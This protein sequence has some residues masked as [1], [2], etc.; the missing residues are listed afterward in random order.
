MKQSYFVKKNIILFVFI[1][2][3]FFAVSANSR[4]TVPH[5]EP[6]R[7]TVRIRVPHIQP[8]E[9]YIIGKY[10]NATE[11]SRIR[12]QVHTIGIV[13]E[14]KENARRNRQVTQNTRVINWYLFTPDSTQ[15]GYYEITFNRSEL[16]RRATFG[17]WRYERINSGRRY[18]LPTRLPTHLHHPSSQRINDSTRIF[19]AEYGKSYLFHYKYYKCQNFPSDIRWRFRKSSNQRRGQVQADA[20][21][22]NLDSMDSFWVNDSTWY[23]VVVPNHYEPWRELH[24]TFQR[25]FYHLQKDKEN[26]DVPLLFL[27]SAPIPSGGRYEVSDS[28]SLA[29]FAI[30]NSD[31]PQ[32][33]RIM[34][35]V[36]PAVRINFTTLRTIP[37]H[38]PL[39]F[40]ANAS[41]ESHYS[42]D[43]DSCYSFSGNIRLYRISSQS[44]YM[45]ARVYQPNNLT[46]RI[47]FDGSIFPA[48]FGFWIVWENTSD[49]IQTWTLEDIGLASV[50]GNIDGVHYFNF[51]Q[52]ATDTTQTWV[53]SVDRPKIEARVITQVDT[54]VML[55]SGNNYFVLPNPHRETYWQLEKD[56]LVTMEFIFSDQRPVIIQSNT[57]PVIGGRSRNYYLQLYNPT[58]AT[59]TF[60]ITRIQ[61][62]RLLFCSIAR[63]ITTFPAQ[64]NFRQHRYFAFTPTKEQEGTYEIITNDIWIDVF[65]GY[66]ENLRSERLEWDSQTRSHT[67]YARAGTTYYFR[68]NPGSQ[69]RGSWTI[70]KR[71]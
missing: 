17:I 36:A 56:S 16:G 45:S 27:R 5:I 12:L 39:P 22:I 38:S 2:F 26:P 20:Q 43:V 51:T 35:K 6:P 41:G 32:N 54:T 67:F 46:Q 24:G 4:G 29:F 19:F 3:P 61:N 23:K 18:I 55:A 8:S 28:I 64:L 66:C 33:W 10:T 15:T 7:E 49:T 42:F 59:K 31:E 69:S 63:E 62:N 44:S 68:V 14:Y 40:K 34:R 37:R 47:D 70:K 53:S 21:R 57:S 9:N 13:R 60:H 11:H 71:Q 1:V 50:L 30:T 52:K 65:T 58:D 48:R 25:R